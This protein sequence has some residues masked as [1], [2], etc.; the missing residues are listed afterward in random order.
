M[1]L[2]KS[3]F[4]NIFSNFSAIFGIRNLL[5]SIELIITNNYWLVFL[6]IILCTCSSRTDGAFFLTDPL[7]SLHDETIEHITAV[8]TSTVVS[9]T[10]TITTAI[11]KTLREKAKTFGQ[12]AEEI[13]KVKSYLEKIQKFEA[14]QHPEEILQQYT[15]KPSGA[16]RGGYFLNVIISIFLG[17]FMNF[18]FPILRLLLFTIF[19]HTF[20]HISSSVTY[21]FLAT[22]NDN[23][24]RLIK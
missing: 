8:T 9:T 19:F 11:Q 1:A 7:V 14:K 12:N 6:V 16:V 23:L 21:S 22:N 5:N 2:L 20:K 10:T 4:G 3:I 15:T 17:D 18:Y 13:Q 24:D